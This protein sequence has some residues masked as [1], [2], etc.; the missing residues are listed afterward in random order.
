[1]PILFCLRVYY[2]SYMRQSWPQRG[3]VVFQSPHSLS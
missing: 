1:M 2:R 3:F